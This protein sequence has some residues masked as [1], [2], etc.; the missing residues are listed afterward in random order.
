MKRVLSIVLLVI[1]F[2]PS[3]TF[4]SG[5]PFCKR[6]ETSC[7]QR[8]ACRC[9]VEIVS[10][11]GE[12]IQPHTL[13]QGNLARINRVPSMSS[14]DSTPFP[15]DLVSMPGFNPVHEASSSN[16]LIRHPA[17]CFA[18]QTEIFREIDSPVLRSLPSAISMYQGPTPLPRAL[19]SANPA[20]EVPSSKSTLFSCPIC[21][22]EGIKPSRVEFLICMHLLCKECYKNMQ[23]RTITTCPLCR[24]KNAIRPAVPKRYIC[25]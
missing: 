6:Y 13:A 9:Q 20:Q 18:D 23:R 24:C 22:C 8:V 19:V 16:T 10:I 1:F 3:V 21:L 7:L 5:C 15:R 25:C 4:G 12:I 2:K 17:I 14:L 11:N